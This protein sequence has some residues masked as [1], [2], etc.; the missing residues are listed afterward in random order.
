MAPLALVSLS[1]ALLAPLVFQLCSLLLYGLRCCAGMSGLVTVAPAT[2][3]YYAV[4]VL[5]WFLLQPSSFTIF[6]FDCYRWLPR[7]T[8]LWILALRYPHCCCHTRFVMHGS[9]CIVYAATS[10]CLLPRTVYPAALACLVLPFLALVGFQLCSLLLYRLR[11]CVGMSGLVN[12]ALTTTWYY[13]VIVLLWF[14][15]AAIVFSLLVWRLFS[16][17]ATAGFLV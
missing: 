12:V 15:S 11:C 14:P 4:I 8:P 13:A 9:R 17:I 6:F 3:L 16:S 5:S 2:T 1:L 7:I 10:S